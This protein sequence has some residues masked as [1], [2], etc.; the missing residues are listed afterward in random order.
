MPPPRKGGGI[1]RCICPTSVCH[2]T[3]I[4]YIGPKS[5]TERPKKTKIGTEVAHVTR[6][7]ITTFKVKGQG[8]QAALLSAAFTHM[9]GAAVSVET[10][11]AWESTAMLR[12][13]GGARRREGRGHIVS[14][15]AQLII[16]IIK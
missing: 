14:P 16:T 13:L 15:R 10:Y 8:H 1:K 7:S 3:Y 11:S 6:D 5:K 12:L 2:V 4:H 9:V